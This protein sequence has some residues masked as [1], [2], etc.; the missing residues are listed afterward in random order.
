MKRNWLKKAL[1]LVEL[2]TNHSIQ[3]SDRETAVYDLLMLLKSG[4]NV[5]IL[6]NGNMNLTVRAKLEKSGMFLRARMCM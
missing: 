6:H 5:E 4:E 1:T 3:F 2:A